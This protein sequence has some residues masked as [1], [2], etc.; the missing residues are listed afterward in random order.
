MPASVTEL[1]L[2]L[3][4]AVARAVEASDEMLAELQGRIGRLLDEAAQIIDLPL[5]T[6]LREELQHAMARHREEAAVFRLVL[7]GRTGAGKSSL[8]EALT[9]GDGT[10]I[11]PGESDFTTEQRSVTWGPLDL[12]D[13]PGIAGWG[14]NNPTE[15]L[16][17]VAADA[18]AR[19]D[20]VILCFDDQNQQA[21]EFEVV[22]R[23]IQRYG[24]PCIAVLNIRNSRWRDSSRP[25]QH[26]AI[27][28][29]VSGHA[30]HLRQELN[31]LGLNACPIVALNT[32]RA[33]AA[34]AGAN[35]A[36]H[37]ADLV[38]QRRASAGPE[39]LEQLSNVTRLEHLLAQ[40]LSSGAPA[41][42]VQAVEQDVLGRV[43][44]GAD[45][46]LVEAGDLDRELA[47]AAGVVARTL[48]IIGSGQPAA[49]P[50]R[51]TRDEL[52]HGQ[53]LT[54]LERLR[55]DLFPRARGAGALQRMAA[56]MFAI[57]VSPHRRR[58]QEKAEEVA[59][60]A[61]NDSRTI[62]PEKLFQHLEAAIQAAEE[63]ARTAFRALVDEFSSELEGLGLTVDFANARHA[64]EQVDGHTSGGSTKA[65]ATGEV[66]AALTALLVFTGPVGWV[67]A[68]GGAIASML[69]G[70]RRR[71]A[72]R[73][74]EVKR[75]K[76]RSEAIATVRRTAE[77]VYTSITD[78]LWLQVREAAQ[79]LAKRA[80]EPILEV[81][82][83]Q[84]RTQQGLTS[85][86]QVLAK[87]SVRKNNISASDV[88]VRSAELFRRKEGASR[89]VDPLLGQDAS[90]A[91]A[92]DQAAGQ[93]T[94]TGLITAALNERVTLWQT[95]L[96][97]EVDCSEVSEAPT[98]LGVTGARGVGVTAFANGLRS[99]LDADDVTIADLGTEAAGAEHCDLLI[100]L[101]PPNVNVAGSNAFPILLGADSDYRDAVQRRSL[102]CITRLDQLGPDLL[103]EPT[104]ALATMERKANEAAD[105]LATHDIA[106]MPA[107]IAFAAPHPYGLEPDVEVD[108]VTGLAALAGGIRVMAP[109]LH[110][111][112]LRHES[113]AAVVN[114][115]NEVTRVRSQLEARVAN[116]DEAL[117]IGGTNVSARRRQMQDSEMQLRSRLGDRVDALAMVV[118]R[119]GGAD[120]LKVALQA[121][122]GWPQDAQVVQILETWQREFI[123][124]Q[125]DLSEDLAAQLDELVA[126]LR[127]ATGPRR[128]APG[129]HGLMPSKAIGTFGKLLKTAGETRDGWY[130][131]V[132]FVTADSYKFKPWG[133][134]KGASK[135]KVIGRGV[136][137]LGVAI[138]ALELFLEHR[139]SE[140][141]RAIQ[142]QVLGDA[143]K[144]VDEVIT[145][146]LH[147]TEDGAKPL[148]VIVEAELQRLDKELARLR[149]E[150]EE[151]DGQLQP[152]VTQEAS[153]RRDLEVLR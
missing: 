116:I 8:V 127:D 17:S 114:T 147:S 37:D 47:P 94:L 75:A 85:A 16:E 7:F 54:E 11:S 46:L 90:A 152:V 95:T 64:A 123:Q 69:F 53:S 50:G 113:L 35:Y 3:P 38:A 28:Q 115:L 31:A 96:A 91:S 30:R 2:D 151:L 78:D 52:P 1:R 14:R 60:R 106:L 66:G 133:A 32:Q 134:I 101:L 110:P 100:F 34:R 111:Q 40:C 149:D 25:A 135:V 86:A 130:N 39:R 124:S 73:A 108:G 150:R 19:A 49:R 36:G 107:A 76:V 131:L 109:H 65:W 132:K 79:A 104:A 20:L 84:A 68:A 15:A 33:V 141:R 4:T 142:H 137:A 77:S 67:V 5:L 72:A 140:K 74:A 126:R 43:R 55:P 18:V 71:K 83:V 145:A 58:L 99:Q 56:E 121:L 21:S 61:L 6:G 138:T 93:K 27:Q 112:R 146:F 88:L 70:W 103:Y 45:A 143:R 153:L 122:G 81:L 23:E 92:H 82:V 129:E 42:R 118:C 10:S 98:T 128:N 120:Q 57:H 105:L 117:A 22:Q 62:E 125:E 136:A 119:A 139:A 29:Q 9:G 59:H 97:K 48:M 80:L 13:T 26:R 87:A 41:L 102:F 44:I 51:W 148:F 24:R 89:G 63:A 12:I 144:S